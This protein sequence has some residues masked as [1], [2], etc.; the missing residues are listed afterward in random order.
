MKSL[1]RF[2]YLLYNFYVTTVT[3]K[4]VCKQNIPMVK[5]FSVENV[6]CAFPV[7]RDM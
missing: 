2:A 5:R 6:H 1:T 4:V 7:S 3:I